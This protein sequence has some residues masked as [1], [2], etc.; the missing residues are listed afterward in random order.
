MAHLEVNDRNIFFLREPGGYLTVEI[1]EYAREVGL[2]WSRVAHCWFT[3]DPYAALCFWD[4]ATPEAQTALLMHE[5][6][7]ESSWCKTSNKEL[8]VPK[9]RD[10]FPFQKA[11]IEYAL[12]RRNTLIG[13]Q[14]GLGKTVQAIGVANALDMNRILVLCPASVRL[15]WRQEILGWS[16]KAP[17]PSTHVILKGSDSVSTQ[18]HYT[19]MSYDLLRNDAIRRNLAR[20]EWDMLVLDEAHYLKNYSAQRTKAVFTGVGR[21]DDENYTPPIADQ[22]GKIIGLT[23]TPLPNRPRECYTIT[24][25]LCWE[26]IDGVSQDSFTH[27]YNP[28][29]AMPTGKVIEKTGR[30][31]E[32]QNRLRCNFMVRRMKTEVLDQL[33]DVQYEIVY[34]EENK[35]VK[36][37]VKA[38]SMLD[39]DPSDMANVSFDMQGHVAEVRRMMGEAKVP[40]VAEHVERLMADGLD[41]VVVYAWHRNVMDMLE[42]KLGKHG[43]LRIDGA[44]SPVQRQKRVNEFISNGDK[45]VFLGQI[46]S[47]GTGTDGLQKVA[48]HV[49]FG[50]CSWTPGENDQA[51]DRLWRFGQNSGVHAQ[52]LVAP[53][54]F[55]ERVIGSALQKVHQINSTLDKRSK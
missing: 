37:A 34:V 14:P 25:G 23:G 35:D 15:Q 52:Y 3:D 7:Y 46:Q 1:N 24:R 43:C 42:E 5:M 2:T 39:I 28:S 27:R 48:S 55:D 41:K 21:K 19:I 50:E 20:M 17:Y 18:A 6:E 53:K 29:A 45:K 36:K 10:Y 31:P 49:V 30:L 51:I 33:P 12:R 13:D 11:G 22:C 38:E 8:P 4:Y 16:T 44:T 54:S 32:L 9:D 26:A 40:L 47:V